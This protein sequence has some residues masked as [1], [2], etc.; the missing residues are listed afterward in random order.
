MRILTRGGMGPPIY[1][2]DPGDENPPK[3]L[4]DEQAQEMT[5]GVPNDSE[6]PE[7]G[8]LDDMA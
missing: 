7:P 3:R 4:T 6:R 8:E 5:S 2:R 1:G